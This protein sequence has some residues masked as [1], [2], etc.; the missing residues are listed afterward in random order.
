MYLRKLSG[1]F[2]TLLFFITS[3]PPYGYP[4]AVISLTGWFC[5][6]SLIISINSRR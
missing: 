5:Q 1:S 4:Y 2:V 6:D 3:L